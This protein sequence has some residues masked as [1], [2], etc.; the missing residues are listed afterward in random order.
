MGAQLHAVVPFCHTRRGNTATPAL[1]NTTTVHGALTR[2]RS[3]CV[4]KYLYL[5]REARPASLQSV[6][7]LLS[8]TQLGQVESQVGDRS[9]THPL[10][11]AYL[12][13]VPPRL[14]R[15]SI[16]GELLRGANELTSKDTTLDIKGNRWFDVSQVVDRITD[17]LRHTLRYFT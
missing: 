8:P 7:S 16:F 15:L 2:D 1:P 3:T 6:L 9:C 13:A 4:P 11:N 14:Y 5:S 17:L 12:N 10:L